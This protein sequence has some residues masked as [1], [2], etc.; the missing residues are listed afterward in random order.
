MFQQTFLDPEDSGTVPTLTMTQ[1]RDLMRGGKPPRDFYGLAPYPLR[2]TSKRPGTRKKIRALAARVARREHL[3]HPHDAVYDDLNA[4]VVERIRNGKTYFLEVLAGLKP[5]AADAPEPAPRPRKRRKTPGQDLPL[6]RLVEQDQAAEP[7]D[8]AVILTFPRRR[9]RPS[10][11]A[12]C[13][14]ATLFD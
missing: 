5:M 7:G 14:G 11:V 3:W 12:A 13:A 10:R 8:E 4:P 2:P 9:R 1:L 6:F